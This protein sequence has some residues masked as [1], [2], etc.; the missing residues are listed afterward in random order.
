MANA[1]C[2]THTRGTDDDGGGF[3]IVEF[4]GMFQ[5]PN[6]GEIF[7]TEGISFF[8]K[9]IINVLVETFRVQTEDFGGIHTQ[10][11]IHKYGHLWQST[12]ERQLVQGIDNHLGAPHRKRRDD[13]FPIFFK[14][15]LDDRLELILGKGFIRVLTVAIGTFD[16][17]K[18]DI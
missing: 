12:L 15:L 16:L 13:D 4:F 10:G 7:H 1:S 5:M 2:L 17:K 14:C 9:E 6:V 3:Q 11:A 8:V 18:V